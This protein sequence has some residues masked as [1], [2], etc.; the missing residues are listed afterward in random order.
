[1][2]AKGR[3]VEAQP[4]RDLINRQALIQRRNGSAL[5]QV[6]GVEIEARGAVGALLADGGREIGESA[7]ALIVGQEMRVEIVRV[8]NR[9]RTDVLRQSRQSAKRRS[10]RKPHTPTSAR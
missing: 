6:A 5:H 10:A 9:K 2:I 8:K 1:M 7:H 4:V 3:D